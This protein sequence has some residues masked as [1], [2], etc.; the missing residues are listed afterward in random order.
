MFNKQ[1]LKDSLPWLSAERVEVNNKWT[2]IGNDL[3]VSFSENER[4]IFIWCDDELHSYTN[5]S[6]EV[7]YR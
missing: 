6:M 5:V 7:V 2:F 3:M 4:T 1:Q